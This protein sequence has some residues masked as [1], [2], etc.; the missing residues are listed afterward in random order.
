MLCNRVPRTAT[1]YSIFRCD[2]KK[3]E[4]KDT[5]ENR[6][7]TGRRGDGRKTVQACHRTEK[8]EADIVF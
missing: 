5:T 6:K 8:M 3:W 4:K 2:Y 1:G 7:G